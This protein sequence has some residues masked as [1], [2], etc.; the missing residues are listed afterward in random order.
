MKSEQDA[1]LRRKFAEI[2]R[3]R[4][5]ATVAEWCAAELRFNE[6]ECNGP[7]SFSGREYLV[8]PINNWADNSVTDQVLVFGTRLGKTRSLYAGLAWLLDNSAVRALY[9]KPKSKGAAG[10][11]DDARTRFI[12]MLRA[13][14]ALARHIP[15]GGMRRHEFKTPQQILKGS[16]ID[17]VGSNSVSALASNPCRVVIQDEVDKFNTTRKKDDAGDVVEADAS[18][19]ADERCKE[20]SNPKRMK[21]STPTLANGIIWQ[22]LLKSDLRRY[23]VP[24]PHCAKEMVWVWSEKYT[25]LPMKDHNGEKIPLGQVRWDE[26]A[27]NSG[28]TWDYSRIESTA[29]IECPHCAGKILDTHKAACVRGG[30]WKPTQKGLPGF[31]GYHLPSLYAPHAQCNF[32]RM[33]VRFLKCF[34]SLD[35]TRGFINSDLAE[36]NSG[37][38]HTVG[39]TISDAPEIAGSDWVSMM[40]CDFQKLWPFIWFVVQKWSSFKLHPP[41]LGPLNLPAEL[42]KKTDALGHDEAA[43]AIL[44]FDNRTGEFPLIEWL[45]AQGITGS[46]LGEIFNGTCQ[47]DAL[48]LGK[49]IARE[50]KINLPKG[51]DSEVIAAGHC[52]LSGD[53]AWDEL[54]EIQQQFSVGA[55]FTKW[56]MSPNRAVVIDAGYA[57]E[58]NPEVLRKC[59][60]SGASG[61]MEFYDPGTKKFVPSRIHGQCRPVP[62]DGWIPFRGYPITKRWRKNGIEN[63]SHWAADD[64][65]KGLAEAERCAVGVL[66]AAS[67]FYFHKWMDAR[68]RQKENLEL[69][70]EGKPYRGNLWTISSKLKLLPERKF[71]IEDFHDQ[72][73]A[74]G[75]KPGGEIWERGKGGSGKRRHPDHLNDCCR[76][77][78]PL[79]EAHG[80]FSHETK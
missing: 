51:G 15:S 63:S 39:F 5:T 25:V 34:S 37:Q 6:P 55:T 49:W 60:E 46:K 67:D 72:L 56:G 40:S 31:R 13:T 4:P 2:F 24:C 75:R 48:N 58:H 47:K 32:G 50:M 61:R 80:L 36:V 62:V 42:K 73:N 68:E 7:F 11:E 30:R 3:A 43:R 70:K 18:T 76:N 28:G 38:D 14:P 8:E 66:E 59:F 64:P 9:V 27:R 69:L 52:E 23:F 65:F 79:A 41:I 33:A 53:D 1:R 35:G 71:T 17:W 22:E 78:Y 20:F 16:I 45:L 26:K 12:P 19:L 54:R 44:R 74:K 10:A 21:A 57:E 29:H 77:M